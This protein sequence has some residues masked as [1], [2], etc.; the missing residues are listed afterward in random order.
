MGDTRQVLLIS[1]VADLDGAASAL[2]ADYYWSKQ[3]GADVEIHFVDYSQRLENVASLLAS[4]EY[5]AVWIMDLAI[6]DPEVLKLNKTPREKTFIFDHH[7]TA[8]NSLKQIANKKYAEVYFD[9]SKCATE[10]VWDYVSPEINKRKKDA[11]ML[12]KL[13]SYARS[14]D[15]W[16]RDLEQGDQ[17][18]AMVRYM[19]AYEFFHHIAEDYR[20]IEDYS[21]VMEVVL[22]VG[23][24][25]MMQSIYFAEN[26]MV[27]TDLTYKDGSKKHN[28]RLITCSSFGSTSDVGNHLVSKH[29]NYDDVDGVYAIMLD[30]RN[31]S[32]SVRTNESTCDITDIPAN[33][34]ASAMDKN[35]GGHKNAAGFQVSK[36]YFEFGPAYLHAE[37]RNWL[38]TSPKTKFK[39]AETPKKK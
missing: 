38:L 1:H 32:C 26:S 34:M 9:D 27:Y 22:E 3:Q 30:G 7:A 15:L 29:A 35:G 36:E 17:L 4:N 11:Q 8:H 37:I 6:L 16:I 10:V 14:R 33:K 25:Q 18:D 23:E 12:K 39:L 19:G 21:E 31:L 28:I 2:V 5:E 20:R 24:K 13:V